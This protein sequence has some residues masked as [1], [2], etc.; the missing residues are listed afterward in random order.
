M[1]ACYSINGTSASWGH[2]LK[3]HVDDEFFN[4]SG[5]LKIKLGCEFNL[6]ASIQNKWATIPF[7]KQG[8]LG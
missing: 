5:L 4:H 7:R 1:E 6:L 8:I 2:P 3:L